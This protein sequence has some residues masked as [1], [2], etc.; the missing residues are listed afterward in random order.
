M[1]AAGPLPIP[2]TIPELSTE[3]E[4]T[5]LDVKLT[6]EISEPPASLTVVVTV[7]VSPG[8]AN[9]SEPG[10]SVIETATCWMDAEAVA[11][12]EFDF[13]VIVA[14]PFATAV[15]RPVE[16]TLATDPE[17]VDHVTLAPL[18]VVPFWSLT[19]AENCCVSPRGEK[20]RLVAESVIDVATGVG[21]GG[22]AVGV[23]S[24]PHAASSSTAV[25]PM[26]LMLPRCFPPLEIR[27]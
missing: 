10:E 9:T 23:L 25:S 5:S 26:C 21:G 12:A 8:L 2:V 4:N 11:D 16:K 24:P 1:I 15:T 19:V 27:Q 14:V 18:I 7:A 17:E 3:T 22:V 20:L 6:A 13:A